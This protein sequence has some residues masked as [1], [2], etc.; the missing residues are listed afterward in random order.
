MKSMIPHHS[1]AINNSREA[2]LRDPRVRYFADR[3]RRDQAKEIAEMKLL[4]A[5]I[6]QNGRRG[7]QPLP[8]GPAELLPAGRDEAASLLKGQLLEREPL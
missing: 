5:D 3:I 2:D 4:I 6:E 7:D 8:A 1:I